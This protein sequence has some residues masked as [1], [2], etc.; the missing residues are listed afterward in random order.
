MQNV[1][2]MNNEIHK[3]FEKQFDLL[4]KICAIYYDYNEIGKD[5]DYIYLQI[6]REIEK[7]SNDKTSIAQLEQ[8]VNKYKENIMQIT[9]DSL[10]DLN[11]KDLRI[12]CFLY[13][14]F[15]AKAICVFTKTTVHSI[16]NKKLRL[17]AK[18]SQSDMPNKEILLKYLA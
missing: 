17:K 11:E 6:K 2:N 8:I 3:L 9:R 14:G 10:P 13:A 16:Y 4:D 15:S 7:F 5:K 1:C 18:I 12:L